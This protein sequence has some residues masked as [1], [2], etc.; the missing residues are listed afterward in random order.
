MITGPVGTGK[1]V[2]AQR[3][4]LDMVRAARERKIALRYIHVNCRECKGSLF[5]VLRKVMD[6]FEEKFPR[7]GFSS[8]ELLQAIM[9]ILD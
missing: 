5:A 2:I 8:E 7:R 9:R 4:G 3:F 1:T 6:R